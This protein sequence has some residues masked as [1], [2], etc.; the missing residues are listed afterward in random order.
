MPKAP[1]APKG[2]H[3]RHR[4]ELSEL[5]A[6]TAAAWTA[7]G[8][9]VPSMQSRSFGKRRRGGRGAERLVL[10]REPSPPAG[11]RGRRARTAT[12]SWWLESRGGSGD[13]QRRPSTSPERQRWGGSWIAVATNPGISDLL[14][15]RCYPALQ[16]LLA[17]HLQT[18]E[19]IGGPET[20]RTSGLCLRR[21]SLTP[22]PAHSGTG[23]DALSVQEAGKPAIA[24]ERR[25]TPAKL[26]AS[27][28]AL[29]GCFQSEDR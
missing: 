1:K 3:R 18:S 8:R 10:C 9:A 20:I 5:P 2:G 26:L 21:A 13:S 12:P 29:S 19:K 24:G 14:L 7:R 25:K 17:G 6:L 4:P 27:R 16:R 11:Q 22:F 28:S 15:P 23:R